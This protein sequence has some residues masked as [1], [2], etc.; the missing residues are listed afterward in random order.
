MISCAQ[1]QGTWNEYIVPCPLRAYK[2][3]RAR[4]PVITGEIRQGHLRVYERGLRGVPAEDQLPGQT[5][6]RPRLSMRRGPG[7]SVERH[8][9]FRGIGPSLQDRRAPAITGGDCFV[10]THHFPWHVLKGPMGEAHC[11]ARAGDPR[12]W[13]NRGRGRSKAVEEGEGFPERA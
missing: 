2:S 7:H 11:L 1:F 8:P 10:T 4:F 12:Q 5:A 6:S 3:H 13:G 9:G